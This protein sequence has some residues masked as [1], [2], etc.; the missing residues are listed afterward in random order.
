MVSLAFA[1][2]AVLGFTSAG[3]LAANG[4]GGGYGYGYGC[5]GY[6]YCPPTQPPPVPSTLILTPATATNTVGDQHCVTATVRDQFGN[7]MSG[8]RVRFSVAG[9]V[10]T[11]G[12]VLTNA[13][14]QAQFCYTGPALPGADV[15]TAYA[16][17]DN[18]NVNDPTPADPEGTADKAWVIPANMVGCKV[19]Y[20]GRITAAN[21]DKAT[22]GGNADGA[23]PKGN[24]NYQD[25]GPTTPMHVKS[26]VIQSVVC[27]TAG[28]TA[29]I[30][31]TASIDGSG[32]FNF[33]IDLKDVG[34][35]GSSDTYR[36]RLS[37]GYD[38]GE[39]VLLGGNVQIH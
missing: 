20:G 27:N 7:P 16:D 22:V 4:Y 25:H 26:I 23:G 24:E 21:G 3:S 30:F 28:T 1:T 13:A 39:R 17:T 14:G 2:L 37:N 35:P 6:G 32:T 11:S 36:I 29:S 38:S 10:T 18:D 33:R 31:G 9:S 5:P 19:T 12:T 34:E 15:I 8:V